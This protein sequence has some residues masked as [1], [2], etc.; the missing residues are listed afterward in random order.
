[1]TPP[2]RYTEITDVDSVKSKFSFGNVEVKTSSL[3]VVIR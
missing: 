2:P 3:E 1:M